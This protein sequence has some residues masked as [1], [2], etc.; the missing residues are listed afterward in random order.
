MGSITAPLVESMGEP[1]WTASVP[2]LW[3]GEGARG[4]VSIGS[5]SGTVILGEFAEYLGVEAKDRV[6]RVTVR[7]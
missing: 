2:N 3:I 6:E 7:L 1:A 5:T 4:G